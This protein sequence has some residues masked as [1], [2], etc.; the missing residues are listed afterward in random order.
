MMSLIADS[1]N[2]MLENIKFLI[3]QNKEEVK[4]GVLLEIKQLESQF[5]PHF[6]FNTL[7]MLKYTIKTDT[8]MANK[9]IL[10]I[11]SN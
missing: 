10:N 8:S 7:E 6:L 2:K 5:N 1:Y 4:H 9:I 11:S 3:E